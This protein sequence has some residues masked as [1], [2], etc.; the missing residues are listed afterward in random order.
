MSISKHFEDE[1]QWFRTRARLKRGYKL[2]LCDQIRNRIS[3]DWI[4]ADAQWK[5]NFR[6]IRDYAHQAVTDA[7][8]ETFLSNQNLKIK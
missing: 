2:T 5:A 6:A 4:K 7:E 1:R 8:I 3:L